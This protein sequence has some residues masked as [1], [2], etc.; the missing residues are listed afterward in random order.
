MTATPSLGGIS[1]YKCERST[2]G[3]CQCRCGG[4]F[5]GANRKRV[6]RD[7]PHAA[8]FYCPCCGSFA[9]LHHRSEL[10]SDS[11]K[12]LAKL[13]ALDRWRNTRKTVA[14]SLPD[15][16]ELLKL[17]REQLLKLLLEEVRGVS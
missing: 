11:P 14:R 7:D 3:R 2:Q 16:E 5:H 4:K 15:K 8:A 12:S 1:A 10:R 6:P 9:P 13:R 17:P